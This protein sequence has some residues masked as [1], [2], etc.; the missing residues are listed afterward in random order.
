MRKTLPVCEICKKSYGPKKGGGYNKRFCSKE[1]LYEAFK[2]HGHPHF[3]NARTYSHG[4]VLISRKGRVWPEHRW[5]MTE[6]LGRILKNSEHVHH[7]NGMKDDNRIE[8]LEILDIKD[9]GRLHRKKPKK[10][11]TRPSPISQGMTWI[12]V[13]NDYRSY[14]VYRCQ[15]CSRLWWSRKDHSSKFCSSKCLEIATGYCKTLVKSHRWNKI[16]KY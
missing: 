6:Y 10:P 13:K 12:D 7:I 8:N 15:N 9:H 16:R 2:G 14:L 5:I 1:C 11:T 3:K 4:Y